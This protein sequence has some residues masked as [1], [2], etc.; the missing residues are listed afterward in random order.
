MKEMFFQETHDNIRNALSISFNEILDNCFDKPPERVPQNTP[1]MRTYG[2]SQLSAV[3]LIFDPLFEELQ[4]GRDRTSRQTA[5]YILRRLNE[6][7]AADGSVVSVQ[8]CQTMAQLG[9]RNRVCDCNFLMGL[10]DL[11][12]DKNLGPIAVLG[13]DL[14]RAMPFFI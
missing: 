12:N 4:A 10:A 11:I 13:K 1:D 6:V 14:E 5:C 3:S 7:Y 8:H 2:K 9:I